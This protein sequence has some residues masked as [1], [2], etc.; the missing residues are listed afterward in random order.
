[1]AGGVRARGG[2]S[3]GVEAGEAEAAHVEPLH[4]RLELRLGAHRGRA[5][6]EFDVLAPAAS[7][8]RAIAPIA[9]ARRRSSALARR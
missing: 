3:A 5:A 2:G 8:T 9:M 4:R 1:M 6:A 7:I